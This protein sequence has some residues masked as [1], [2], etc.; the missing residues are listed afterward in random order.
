[1]VVGLGVALKMQSLGSVEGCK[2]TLGDGLGNLKFMLGEGIELSIGG[3]VASLSNKPDFMKVGG[4][5][6]GD[7]TSAIVS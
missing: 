3:G 1:M 2:T 5:V 6:L 7:L 4:G